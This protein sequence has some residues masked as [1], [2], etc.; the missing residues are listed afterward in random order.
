MCKNFENDII[1]EQVKVLRKVIE[2]KK[3]SNGNSRTKEYNI[4][5]IKLLGLTK[6]RIPEEKQ[7]VNSR[8]ETRNYKIDV[9]RGEKALKY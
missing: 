3:K 8:T 7:S 4:W 2:S 5:N 9:R 1:N 6:D